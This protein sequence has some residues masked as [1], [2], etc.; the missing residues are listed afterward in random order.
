MRAVLYTIGHGTRPIDELVALL[1]EHAIAL[2]VDVRAFPGS[3]TNPQF[4]RAHLERRLREAGI[5][6]AW[7]P[8]LGGRR[9]GLGARSPNTAWRNAG[10]RA[11]ADYMLADAFWDAL[12]ELLD[13]AR[14]RRT[15]VMCSETL[16]WRCHRRLIADAATARGVSVC[17]LVKPGTP[18]DPHRVLS[19][20]R[21]V[22]DRVGYA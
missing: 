8:E 15:A 5:A 18:A 19:P 17:H 7:R 4:V 21:I 13:D 2:L 14:R 10:F 6:Y 9:R 1:H 12:D 20:A 22:G 16:W 3:R 11:Y